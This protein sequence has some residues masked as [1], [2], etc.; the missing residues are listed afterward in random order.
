[1][2]IRS[3]NHSWQTT[4]TLSNVYLFVILILLILNGVN[5]I[6][7]VQSIKHR[8]EQSTFIFL[9]NKFAGLPQFLKG[10]DRVGYYTDR[11]IS[12]KAPAAQ[13]AQAQLILAPI[14]L[15][16]K[17]LDHEYII[18]DC[19]SDQVAFKKIKEINAVPMKKNQF[20]IILTKSKK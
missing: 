18:F 17:H 2:N 16:P 19:T 14:I 5:Y 13:F 12:D 15:D 1:M 9:G 3:T 4:L 7:R 20:G 6:N 8:R 11:D 10:V